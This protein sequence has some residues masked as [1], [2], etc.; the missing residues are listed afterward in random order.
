[1]HGKI[2]QYDASIRLANS[3]IFRVSTS[4]RLTMALQ[5][6]EAPA[7]NNSPRFSRPRVVVLTLWPRRALVGETSV[8]G[9]LWTP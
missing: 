4:A 2:R 9:G 1:M 6:R 5:E 8:G 7:L 3:L